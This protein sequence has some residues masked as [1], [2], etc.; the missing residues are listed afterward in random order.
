MVG[1]DR[2]LFYLYQKIFN[3][4]NYQAYTNTSL[5]SSWL[6][7]SFL[8]NATFPKVRAFPV[9]SMNK[10]SSPC[11]KPGAYSG[12][13]C[14]AFAEGASVAR[15]DLAPGALWSHRSLE[16][17]QT[18]VTFRRRRFRAW[19]A[20]Q[21]ERGLGRDLHP[22]ESLEEHDFPR[23]TTAFWQPVSKK[24]EP[25]VSCVSSFSVILTPFTSHFPSHT[26]KS[27]KER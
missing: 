12:G 7:S 6:T 18:S 22:P 24:Q 8:S 4:Q 16:R 9:E 20:S 14:Q 21:L 15:A 11:D 1:I 19:K 10:P 3:K 23:K 5:H 13:H 25:K 17:E 26:D 27:N 2:P